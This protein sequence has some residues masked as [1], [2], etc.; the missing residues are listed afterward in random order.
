MDQREVGRPPGFHY[1]VDRSP[2]GKDDLSLANLDAHPW[3]SPKQTGATGLQ[4]E[5]ERLR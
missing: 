3:P 2:F 4:R 5:A 1:Y